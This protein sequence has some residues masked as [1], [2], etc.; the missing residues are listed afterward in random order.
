VLIAFLASLLAV[1][2]GVTV[3]TAVTRRTH[4]AHAA[5]VLGMVVLSWGAV[6]TV[7]GIWASRSAA[8]APGLTQMDRERIRENGMGAAMY[9]VAT[10]LFI[11]LPALLVSRRVLRA[12]AE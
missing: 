10:A 8:S 9:D 4:L 5:R 12:R 1:T 2:L 11:G 6:V 7:S 3:A